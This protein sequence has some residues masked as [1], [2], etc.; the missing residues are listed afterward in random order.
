[1]DLSSDD[2][3]GAALHHLELVGTL[4]CR[5]ELTA[6][7]GIAIPALPGHLVLAMVTKGHVELN[8]DGEIRMLDAGTALLLTRGR[9]HTATS[10]SDAEVVSLFDLPV[11]PVNQHYERLTTGGGGALSVVT[12]AVLRFDEVSGA[13]LMAALPAVLE[14]SRWD[15]DAQ[16]WLHDVLRLAVHEASEM[17]PGG[18]TVLTRLSD[19]LVIQMIRAWLL[20]SPNRET[21]WLAAMREPGIGAALTAMHETPEKGW[22]V[23]SLAAVA[24]MSRSSFSSRFTTMVGEPVLRYLTEWR[25]QT[26]RMLLR[27]D[28]Q[29]M[30]AIAEA[31]GYQSEASFGR[32]FK[33]RFGL[34]PGRSRSQDR[35]I[36]AGASV[37][38]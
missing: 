20:S 21:G 19:V 33:K 27:R 36:V 38:P 5:A 34:S 30:G 35:A 32:A 7:W 29:T 24:G 12:Y 16:T 15:S 23:A 31:V 3:L 37:P 22:T 8:L 10:S 4:Y 14:A 11:V 2:P 25:L 6:P 13:R 28:S 1:M 26:A 18:E 17:R 9:A